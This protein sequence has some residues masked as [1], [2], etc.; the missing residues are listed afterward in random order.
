LK[1][2]ILGG[3]RVKMRSN[4]GK[5]SWKFSAV[6]DEK[7]KPQRQE[8]ALYILHVSTLCSQVPSSAAGH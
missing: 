6:D 2:I 1:P 5:L 7:H 8:S 3:W 4:S